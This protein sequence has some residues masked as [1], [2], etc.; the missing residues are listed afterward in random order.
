VIFF[1]DELPG[2]GLRIRAGG[3][4]VW[5]VQYRFGLKQRRVT[6]GD[7]RKLDADAAR[8]EAKKRLAKVTLGTDPQ[9]EKID[10]RAK[11]GNTVHAVIDGFLAFKHST[12]RPKHSLK[13]AGI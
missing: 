9:R 2:F 6:L 1:D 7:L 13:R 11:A 3:K 12:L 4:R 10:A 8:V 5:I